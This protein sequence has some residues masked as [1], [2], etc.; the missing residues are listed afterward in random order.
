MRIVRP[1]K[2]L[3]FVGSAV[4]W[5]AAGTVSL[6]A[7]EIEA[8]QAF[9]L[10]RPAYDAVDR[11]RSAKRP[12]PPVHRRFRPLVRPFPR[13][14]HSALRRIVRVLPSKR[15]L[16]DHL[17][18]RAHWDYPGPLRWVPRSATSFGWGRPRLLLGNQKNFEGR[19]P[20]PIGERGSFQISRYP[21]LPVPLNLLPL[22]IAFTTPNGYHFRL[23][24]RWDDVDAYV[25]LPSIAVK[26][27]D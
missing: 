8:R 20:K 24:A 2:I 18:H 4:L 22:Y 7:Q 21:R 17:A 19:H 15:H 9:A 26:K 5:A 27:I 11:P 3:I 13:F 16:P 25:T 1:E 23:G 12:S 6:Q 10:E 14:A